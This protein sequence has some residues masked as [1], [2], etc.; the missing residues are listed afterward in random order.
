MDRREGEKRDIETIMKLD[1][2][3]VQL[4]QKKIINRFKSVS[5]P[6]SIHINLVE[7][8]SNRKKRLNNE[9]MNK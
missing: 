7:K 5:K 9:Q 4:I 3:F 2:G 6:I 1:L 8:V